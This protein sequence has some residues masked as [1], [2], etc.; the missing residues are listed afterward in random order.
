MDRIK[1]IISNIWELIKNF[2]VSLWPVRV[3]INIYKKLANNTPLLIMTLVAAFFAG[4]YMNHLYTE[5]MI[6][7]EE[8]NTKKEEEKEEVKGLEFKKIDDNL[9]TLTGNVEAG[10]CE[11]IVPEL[12]DSFTVILESPGGN[13]AEGSCL[14]AHFKLRQVVTVVRADEVINDVGKVIYTPGTVNLDSEHTAEHM[15]DKTMCAS[16]CGLMFLAGDKR[17]LIG[18]VYFGIHGPRTP[19]EMVTKMHPAAV[20]ASA[21]KTASAL[22]QLLERLEVDPALRLLFIQIPGAS[23]YWLNP[24]DFEA[25]PELITI[26]TNYRDFW[27]LTVNHLEGGV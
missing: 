21:Y 15:K 11:K 22:L 13:L 16:A 3:L 20:E 4:Q 10:D 2:L 12:P 27:D 5:Y 26:A 18:D 19:E 24:R 9:Y 17:Y 1:K 6:L 23:M 25:K 8:A 7:Y 14:A